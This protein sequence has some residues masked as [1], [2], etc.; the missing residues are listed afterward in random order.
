MQ[1]IKITNIKEIVKKSM[2]NIPLK[3]FNAVLQYG[4]IESNKETFKEK[5]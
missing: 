3:L 5:N 4:R 2:Q 1:K